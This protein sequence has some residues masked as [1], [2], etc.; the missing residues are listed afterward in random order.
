MVKNREVLKKMN[1]YYKYNPW[2]ERLDRVCKEIEKK[3][4]EYRA[5]NPPINEISLQ[6]KFDKICKPVK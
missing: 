1:S 6:E 2:Q 5:K 3:G 4:D